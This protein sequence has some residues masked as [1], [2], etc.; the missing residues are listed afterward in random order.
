ML[1]DVGGRLVV[2]A[3]KDFGLYFDS[4]ASF[5]AQRQIELVLLV[6]LLDVFDFI[7]PERIV[8]LLLKM[9]AIDLVLS[10]LGLPI[11]LV[12]PRAGS[13]FAFDDANLILVAFVTEI[14]LVVE[15]FSDFGSSVVSRLTSRL[16][17]R[18]KSVHSCFSMAALWFFLLGKRGLAGRGVKICHSGS[19][20][21]LVNL[22]S[23][24]V[25]NL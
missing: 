7:S 16:G 6:S 20:S 23:R 3:F 8:V 21:V 24:D 1:S 18:P 13:G 25:L 19:E 2:L 22:F 9:I 12:L 10:E 17:S 4:S 5:L 11:M 15:H 14:L